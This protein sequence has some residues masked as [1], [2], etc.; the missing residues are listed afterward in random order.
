MFK[1]WYVWLVIVIIVIGGA[2]YGVH[3]HNVKVKADRIAIIK[4]KEKRFNIA[5]SNFLKTES[6]IYSFYIDA[7][8]DME[9][10]WEK[11]IEDD[12]VIYQGKTY[13]DIDSL[14]NAVNNYYSGKRELVSS[15]SAATK[16]ANT[17]KENVTPKNKSTLNDMKKLN[18]DLV[19]YSELISNPVGS[20]IQVSESTNR[21][22][23]KI[24]NEFTILK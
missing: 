16:Q 11:I 13:K 12:S 4:A 21:Y 14:S 3:A 8:N 2:A 5:K 18:K 24:N 23:H 20:Y 9:E 10:S 6:K 19:A 15:L 22:Y 1:K 17:L 7:D